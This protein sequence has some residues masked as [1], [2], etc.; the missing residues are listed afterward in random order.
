MAAERIDG[1]V[2]P[3]GTNNSSPAQRVGRLSLW[4]AL[5]LLL[6][7]VL[8]LVSAASNIL[9]AHY[10]YLAPMT[11]GNIGAQFARTT[12]YGPQHVVVSA[13]QPQ[14]PLRVL[15]IDTG[16]QLRLD[17]GWDD[18]RTLRAGEPFGFTWL[19]R[20]NAQHLVVAVPPAAPQSFTN[21]FWSHI[22]L[23]AN[24]PLLLVGLFVLWRSRGELG[25]IALGM[26]FALNGGALPFRWPQS[27]YEYPLWHVTI[28]LGFVLVS[29]LLLYFT[30]DYV[31]RF[32]RAVRSWERGTYATLLG[33]QLA[34]YALDEYSGLRNTSLSLVAPIADWNVVIQIVGV[35]LS[36]AYLFLGLGQSTADQRKRYALLICALALVFFPVIVFVVLT[37]TS[38]FSRYNAQSLVLMISWVSQF[39]GALLLV[40]VIFRHK[41]LDLGFVINRTLIYGIVSTA[42]LV[43]FGLIEW[44][45]ERLLPHES[46]GVSALVNASLALTIFLV[47]HRVRDAIER[48]VKRLLFRSWYDKE[49]KLRQFGKLSAFIGKP[50]AL[51]TATIAACRRFCGGAEAALYIREGDGYVCTEGGLA[52]VAR[53]I[54]GDETAAVAMR[55][56]RAALELADTDSEIVAALALPMF[57]RAELDGFIL[58]GPKRTGEGYRP[59][60]IEVLGSITQQVGLDFHAFKVAALEQRVLNLEARNLE[61]RELVERKL[62]ASG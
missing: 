60:E 14:S 8:L 21:R 49:A 33:L 57:H 40:Y 37:A 15:G 5:G 16:D 28:N 29:W 9:E 41:V 7:G 34:V 20:G 27:A 39:L 45:S 44:A 19:A 38:G 12:G 3:R 36:F 11:I 24:A 55:H 42:M 52:G 1:T 13:M 59:D 61:M 17:H 25:V 4:R 54:D 10:V 62:G 18:L 26:A 43:A 22:N 47:F 56:D 58:L 46:I 23:L 32:T 50:E 6:C 31:A 53:H 35:M 51:A 48:L 2:T 30:M